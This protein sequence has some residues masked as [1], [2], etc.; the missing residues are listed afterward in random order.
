LGE[1]D[2]AFLLSVIARCDSEG[3]GVSS[4]NQI[5][6]SS[7]AEQWTA[8]FG[9][10]PQWYAIHTRSQHEK[11]V[12]A[13]LQ[14]QG[15]A[16]FL[17]LVTEVHR[18]SDR[19]KLVRLPLFSCYTFVHMPFVPELWAKVLRV[20]GVLRFVG[21]QGQGVPI[22]E[23]Q[24]ESIRTILATNALCTLCPFLK[25]GQHVRIRGGA[26]EGI[27]GILVERNGDRTVVIS[28][29][30][31]QRSIAVRIDDYQVEPI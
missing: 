4:S 22:P 14:G 7:A 26:L 8:R 16:T 21:V 2:K 30:P 27:E 1:G 15:I 18:W 24:M 9:V 13:H 20:S 29:E 17:P 5:H 25:V 3:S 28:V 12:A 19:R 6:E 10:E 31:I 23:K 11:S